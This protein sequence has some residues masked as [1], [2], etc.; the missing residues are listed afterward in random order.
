MT[1]F[2]LHPQLAQDCIVVRDLDLCRL[3]LMNNSL[4][5][6]CLLVPVRPGLRELHELGSGEQALLMNESTALSLAMLDIFGGE[7]MNIAALGNMVPQL[8]IHHIVRTSNDP[9][10]P[11]PVWG[12]EPA[13]AYSNKRS[14]KL[15]SAL[16]AAFED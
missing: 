3:L 1:G 14:A 2:V 7:K 8:H 9:A 13:I 12:H 6:W 4:Y 15:V 10:W 5:P 11:Q 16:N